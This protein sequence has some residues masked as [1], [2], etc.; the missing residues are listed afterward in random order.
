VH[1]HCIDGDC[2]AQAAVHQN[3][4]R[5]KQVLETGENATPA[6]QSSR[7]R[8]EGNECEHSAGWQQIDQVSCDLP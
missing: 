1:E 4:L 7:P 2:P 3:L 6:G 8:E 5:L